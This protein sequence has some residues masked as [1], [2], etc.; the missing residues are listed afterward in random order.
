MLGRTWAAAR[1]VA[2]MQMSTKST[3]THGILDAV[4]QESEKTWERW[5]ESDRKERAQLEHQL[6]QQ[7]QQNE[8][9]TERMQNKLARLK[10]QSVLENVQHYRQYKAGE[11]MRKI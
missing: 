10:A 3:H 9:D 4:L 11:G 1:I 2:Q 8:E 7:Q 6:Q 5:S